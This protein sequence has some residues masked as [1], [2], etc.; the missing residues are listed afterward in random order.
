MA[1]RDYAAKRDFEATPEPTGGVSTATGRSLCIQKH[2]ATRLHYDLRLEHDGV[3][4]S[5]AVTKGPSPTPS[6]SGWR[7]GPRT[8][9]SAMAA[10]RG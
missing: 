4:L 5:W 8:I 9:R 3:L 1:L 2:D 6:R 7:C 10:S